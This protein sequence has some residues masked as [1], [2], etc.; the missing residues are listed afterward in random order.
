MQ[1]HMVDNLH[2]LI[3][4]MT[5]RTVNNVLFSALPFNRAPGA[6]IMSDKLTR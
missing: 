4:N 3:I 1:I 2:Q 6:V 5:M